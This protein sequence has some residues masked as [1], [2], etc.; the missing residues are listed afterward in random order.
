MPIKE[1]RRLIREND[2]VSEAALLMQKAQAQVQLNDI[3]AAEQN[4]EGVIPL[5]EHGE[6]RVRILAN[7]VFSLRPTVN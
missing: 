3:V 6:R 1:F 2:V 5:L 7:G 4:V